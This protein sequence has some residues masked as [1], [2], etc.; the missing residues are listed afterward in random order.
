MGDDFVTNDDDISDIFGEFAQGFAGTLRGEGEIAF[1]SRLDRRSLDY[2]IQ[3][4]KHV[5]EYLKWVHANRKKLTQSE[6]EVTVLWGGAYVGEVIRRNARGK[7]A[8][9]DHE[10]LLEAN[11]M[12]RNLLPDRSTAT[13]A[14]LVFG[15]DAFTLPLNK[16][17]RFIEEGPE[18]S[19]HY[20]ASIQC[21][22]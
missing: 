5:D 1:P 9:V 3:S 10:V 2:S 19:V 20:Y 7:H 13:C 12:A 18:N 16:I 6:W 15:K 8:W 21:R 22:E 4:L 11:E 14:V 17:A